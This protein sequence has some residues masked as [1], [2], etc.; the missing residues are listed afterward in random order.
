MVERKEIIEDVKRWLILDCL[1]KEYYCPFE[2]L[3][4]RKY[5]EE[6]SSYELVFSYQVKHPKDFE[7]YCSMCKEITGYSSF[8]S[9]KVCPC[10][11]LGFLKVSHLV[12]EWLKK[13]EEENVG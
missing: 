9:V 1:D 6:P 12:E 5:P 3:V 8:T 2:F 4:N 13:Q 10:R 11:V 7:A